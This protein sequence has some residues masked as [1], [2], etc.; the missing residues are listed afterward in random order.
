MAEILDA[1]KRMLSALTNT[2]YIVSHVLIR[3][4]TAFLVPK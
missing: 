1:K 3:K 4:S 2:V